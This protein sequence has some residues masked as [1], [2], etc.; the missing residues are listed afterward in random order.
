MYEDYFGLHQRPFTPAPQICRYFPAETIEQA[1]LAAARCLD[2]AEG[3]AILIGPSGTGKTLLC[4]MLRSRLGADSSVVTLCCGRLTSIE[5]LYQTILFQLGRPYRGVSENELRLDLVDY[6]TDCAVGERRLILLVDEAHTLSLKLLEEIRMLTNVAT[7]SGEPHV[8]V[9][10]AGGPL[11]EE[12]FAH[13]KLESFSQRITTRCYLEAF[14]QA[15]TRQYIHAQIDAVGGDGPKLFTTKATKAV[16]QATDGIP[17]LVNQVCDHALL[18]GAQEGKKRIDE[19]EVEIAWADLQQLPTPW[20]DEPVDSASVVEFGSL[21]NSPYCKSAPSGSRTISHKNTTTDDLLA[22]LTAAS[23]SLEA[24]P[25]EQVNQKPSEGISKTPEKVS[26]AID[27]LDLLLDVDVDV[28]VEEEETVESILA[29]LFP[30]RESKIFREETEPER[31]IKLEIEKTS[32]SD[33]SLVSRVGD[34]FDERFESEEVVHQPLGVHV[35]RS[36]IVVPVN[37]PMLS[38][39]PHAPQ[40]T[41]AAVLLGVNPHVP[42]SM[43]DK[44]TLFSPEEGDSV[45]VTVNRHLSRIFASLR[46][47]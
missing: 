11:L 12:R 29:D 5:S 15:E 34:P 27:S 30:E 19:R 41:E 25:S 7:D 4:Q 36:P 22:D 39:T 21:D 18:L 33:G 44:L 26:D 1:R 28:D 46:R 17:R 3:V 47:A 35:G 16:F 42:P 24:Q 40:A 45:D 37:S 9:L 2:R 14:T 23:A 10:L 31:A 8:R 20:N 43:R 6:L 13:P 38:Y 32:T